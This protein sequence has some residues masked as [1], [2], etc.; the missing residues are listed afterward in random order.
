[1]SIMEVLFGMMIDSG[2]QRLEIGARTADFASLFY[3]GPAF[4]GCYLGQLLVTPIL[5]QS[6]NAPLKFRLIRHPRPAIFEIDRQDVGK[7]NSVY[8]ACVAGG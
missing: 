7:V 8:V 4:S 1:M 3:V 6:A 2:P 5:V